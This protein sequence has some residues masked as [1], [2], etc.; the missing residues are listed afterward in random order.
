MR[1]AAAPVLAGLPCA[2]ATPYRA[3]VYT[4]AGI[5]SLPTAKLAAR[6]LR[7]WGTGRAEIIFNRAPQRDGVAC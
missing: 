3:P 6:L 1:A 7:D 5:S 4:R 2:R